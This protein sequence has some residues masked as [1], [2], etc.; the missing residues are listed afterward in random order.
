MPDLL[1]SDVSPICDNCG[2][3]CDDGYVIKGGGQRERDTDY[4]DS[5]VICA[6]CLEE[7]G[8]W[9]AADMAYDLS[10]GF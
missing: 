9:D 2:A 7:E 4:E 3:R 8:R 5:E 1:Y 10:E 6:A